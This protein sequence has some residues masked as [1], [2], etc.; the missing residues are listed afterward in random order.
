[1]SDILTWVRHYI[2]YNEKLLAEGVERNKEYEKKMNGRKK[3]T[4]VRKT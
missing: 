4:C 1:M 2:N 3:T